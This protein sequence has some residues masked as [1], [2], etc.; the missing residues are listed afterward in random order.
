MKKT[1]LLLAAISILV[2][3]CKKEDEDPLKGLVT[4]ESGPTYTNGTIVFTAQIQF[5]EVGEAVQIEYQLLEGDVVLLSETLETQNA[6]GGLGAF[7]ISPD[8]TITLDPIEDF[9]GKDLTIWLD[10][11]N[12]VTSDEYTD[13]MNVDLWK[14]E[15]VSIP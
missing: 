13:D 15:T 12:K 1:I 9:S 6:D 11:E 14:K 3:S 10:P 7:F 4:F 8:V 5:G 2:F